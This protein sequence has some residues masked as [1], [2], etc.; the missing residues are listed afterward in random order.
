MRSNGLTAL[1]Y[2]PVAD[3]EPQ[4]AA[5]L[6]GELRR[7]GIAAYIK[8]VES[9]SAPGF[10]APEFRTAVRE[11]L[12]VDTTAC[13]QVRELIAAAEVE[14]DLENDDLTWAQI[15]A[16]YDSP[17]APGRATW[18]AEEDVDDT[19]D[20]ERPLA[21]PIQPMAPQPPPARPAWPAVEP[22]VNRSED[23]FIPPEPPPLPHLDPYQQLAWVGLAG[24]PLLLLMAALFAVALPLWLSLAA[25][26]G[27]VGGFL[28]LV[29]TMERRSEDD[30]PSDDGAVV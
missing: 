26:L 11:R 18:P 15:I 25:V 30:G 24:G 17:V 12:Y 27:F 8:P 2:T 16:G 5:A 20:S 23:P 7:Q 4:F 10:A 1:S 13:R 22:P 21:A 9:T 19:A 29:A 28:T 6:L 14:S 3:L